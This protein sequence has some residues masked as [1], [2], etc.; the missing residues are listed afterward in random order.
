MIAALAYAR[1]LQELREYAL[2]AKLMPRDAR[3]CVPGHDV[4]ER[5]AVLRKAAVEEY[6]RALET[7][8]AQVVAEATKG[9]E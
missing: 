4:I 3:A 8:E 6:A 9:W 7:D 5:L 2:T 1:A